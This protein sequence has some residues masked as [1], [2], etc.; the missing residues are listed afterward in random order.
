MTNYSKQFKQDALLVAS[1][2]GTTTA[3]KKLGICRQTLTRWSRER[4]KE[5]IASQSPRS[6]SEQISHRSA[7]PT[8]PCGPLD[9]SVL[10]SKSAIVSRI[11]RLEK[12]VEYLTALLQQNSIL[13]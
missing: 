11:A 6:A 2:I 8:I 12:Q 3:A 13:D 1:I 9:S 4:A 7:T 5:I 10:P